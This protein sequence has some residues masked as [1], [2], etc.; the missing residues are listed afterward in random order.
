MPGLWSGHCA[1]P[2]SASLSSLLSPL[3]LSAGHTDITT[4]LL[5]HVV[6]IVCSEA[7]MTGT[8]TLLLLLV[9]V[10]LVGPGLADNV[11]DN[12]AS[13]NIDTA[14]TSE[15]IDTGTGAGDALAHMIHT[16]LVGLEQ[17]RVTGPGYI[18]LA[19]IV[20][21]GRQEDKVERMAANLRRSASGGL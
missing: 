13:D 1:G 20:V 16:E 2:G 15:N 14:S 4:L 5:N 17:L 11:S 9:V 8:S 3:F 18:H 12:G 21:R 6:T 7:E 19:M 10:L